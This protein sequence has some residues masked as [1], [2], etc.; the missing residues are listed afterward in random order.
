M[1]ASRFNKRPGRSAANLLLLGAALLF[2]GC[3]HDDVPIDDASTMCG[4]CGEV[5]LGDATISGDARLDGFFKAVGTLGNAAATIS[6]DFE[7]QLDQLAAAFEVDVVGMGLAEKVAAVKEQIL[8][9][10]SANV[11]GELRVGYVPPRCSANLSVAVEAQG[12]CEAKAGC[13]VSAEC[14]GGQLSVQCDG[15]CKGSCSGTCEGEC[16]FD[17]SGECP[18]TCKGA[19]EMSASPGACEGTCNGGCAGECS[20]QDNEGNCKGQC[21]GDCSGTC[22]PPSGGMSC[23]GECHGQCAAQVTA[24]CEG[25]CEGWCDAECSGGCQGNAIPPSCAAAGDCEATIDCQVAAAAEAS[26]SLECTPPSLEIDFDFN[27]SVEASAQAEF[28]AKMKTF[29]VKMVAMVQGMTVLR[30][31]VDP[32]YAADL[33]I[34]PSLQVLEGQIDALINA[35]FRDFDVPKGKSPCLIPAFEDSIEIIG[36]VATDTAGTISGQLE[37]FAIIG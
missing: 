31:L 26:A 15:Q 12:Q 13:E 35:D 32:G 5:A 14:S 7:D 29:R 6:G 3:D 21:S 33:G 19:C 34:E 25:K 10:I 18:Y 27:A 24:E 28:L 20:L 9:E 36:G 16:A 30:A 4:P 8:A 1:S 37:L 23:A 22:E 2:P 17:V 11:T